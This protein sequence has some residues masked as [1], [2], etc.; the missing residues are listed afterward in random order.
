MPKKVIVKTEKN[1]GMKCLIKNEFFK[2]I[3]INPHMIKADKQKSELT[4]ILPVRAE[5][6]S[7]FQRV[8]HSQNDEGGLLESS[9]FSLTC[10]IISVTKL[11][12]GK[13]ALT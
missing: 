3:K 6:K 12:R 8:L 11:H 9:L 2:V 5:K 1:Y 10:G 13:N 7:T 4:E